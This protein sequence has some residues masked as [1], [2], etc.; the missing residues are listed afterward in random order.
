MN[1]LKLGVARRII[2]PPVGGQ[3]YGYSPDVMSDSVNDDLTVTAFYFKQNDTEALMISATVCLIN[4]SLAQGI[5]LK[6]EE[7]FGIS[8]ESI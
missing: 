7:G 6:I 5:L 2:T 3:L 8:K 1:K 4:T